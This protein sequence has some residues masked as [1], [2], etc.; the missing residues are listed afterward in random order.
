[1]LTM[2]LAAALAATPAQTDVAAATQWVT[3]ID[4]RQWP[5]SWAAAGTLFKAKMPE[6]KWASTVEPVREPLGPVSSRAVKS[7][8]ATKSLPGAPDG[9]YEIVQYQTSF[10]NKADATETVILSREGS[11]WKVDGYFIR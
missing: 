1:M 10:A 2:L 5:Q 8:T 4:A 9:D 7:V 6:A 3:L 11:G